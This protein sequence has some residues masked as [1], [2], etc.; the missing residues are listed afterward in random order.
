MRASLQL[1]GLINIAEVIKTAQDHKCEYAP[2]N[3]TYDMEVETRTDYVRGSME[4]DLAAKLRS[5]MP[6]SY[7][8]VWAKRA[9]VPLV[10]Y[11]YGHKLGSTFKHGG[12]VDLKD[13]SGVL[14]PIDDDR[15]VALNDMVERSKLWAALKRCDAFGVV[16]NRCVPKAWFDSVDGRVKV[17]AYSMNHV[18]ACLHPHFTYSLDMAPTV[19]LYKGRCNVAVGSESTS[20]DIWE[21]WAK[22]PEGDGRRE[23][24][25][26][27]S[28][29]YEQQ[30]GKS[31]PFDDD[32]P[33]I[34]YRDP[35][36]GEPIYPFVLVKYDV[37][38]D[39]YFLDKYGMLETNRRLNE[40]LTD[41]QFGWL[42]NL[43]PAP[44]LENQGGSSIG[45]DA[46]KAVTANPAEAL[47]VPEGWTLNF[48]RP[49][50]NV[51]QAE[52][53]VKLLAKLEGRMHGVDIE[54]AF[55]GAQGPASGVSI[56]IRKADLDPIVADIRGIVHE[57]YQEFIRR[58]IIVH[59]HHVAMGEIDSTPINPNGD[60]DVVL[61]YARA[62][63][64]DP[65]EVTSTKLP[66][67]ERNIY[68]IVD[69][70]MDL[71]GETR[72]QA[73]ESI[74]RNKSENNE[75]GNRISIEGLA[76]SMSFDDV[77]S[78]SGD[79]PMVAPDAV[80]GAAK[81]DRVNVYEMARAIEVGAATAVDLRMSMFG[82]DRDTATQRIQE[83]E[84]FN[85]AMAEVQGERTRTE[86]E[87][88]GG[89]KT[90]GTGNAPVE[91]ITP[92]D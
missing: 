13:Q 84:Q 58:M 81:I 8:Q 49:D 9:F 60:L 59:D 46:P 62:P 44:V 48:K 64:I 91:P 4:K 18:M 33:S 34:P 75:Y 16:S 65:A 76:G 74:D 30:G 69:L 73:I 22:I 39:V 6:N 24:L 40:L 20:N 68:S 56:R 29:V 79:A 78:G 53:S 25:G 27:D 90:T 88:A 54:V 21:I 7:E 66:L 31:Y 61:S 71:T 45:G 3:G 63:V 67:I 72:A 47:T 57:P 85:I 70:R 17:D 38:N 19:A 89:A 2:S 52:E 35:L 41:I 37:E 87:A 12:Q 14:L 83:A 28:L 10:K 11:I 86:A 55:D 50:A 82:E 80:I 26:V 92:D 5:L 23:T 15:V 51:P 36:T 42:F 32:S 43:H 1:E 77:D